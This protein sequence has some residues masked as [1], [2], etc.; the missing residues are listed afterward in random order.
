MQIDDV[1]H[2]RR[3]E[4]ADSEE[5][6]LRALELGEDG[7]LRD[8]EERRVRVEHLDDVAEADHADHCGDRGFERPEPETLQPEDPEG[9]DRGEDR[10]R[11]EVDAEEE[12][13]PERGAEELGEVGRHRDHLGLDPEKHRCAP[14]EALAA[15]LRQ[16]HA[17]GDAELRRERLDEHRHEVGG[18]DHPDERV[19]EL[20]PS[21]DV[22]REVARVDVGDGGNEGRPEK[23]QEPELAAA[24]EDP[25]T[26][27]GSLWDAFEARSQHEKLA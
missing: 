16:V 12:V 21:G 17:G 1:R 19:A 26:L 24:L 25:L 18:D 22:R 2:D 14:R 6:R 9:R 15:D 13:E 10:G 11:E 3:A 4:D 7:V 27:A 23:R 8:R 5:D 20:R